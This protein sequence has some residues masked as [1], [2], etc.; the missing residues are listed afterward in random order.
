MS[1]GSNG[2]ARYVR[3]LGA[4]ARREVPGGGSWNLAN[5]III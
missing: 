2:R 3:D 5:Q 1:T 4:V